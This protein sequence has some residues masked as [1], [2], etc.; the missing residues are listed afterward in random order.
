VEYH[1]YFRL[2]ETDDEYFPYFRRRH[3]F[4]RIYGLD[5]PDEVLRKVYYENALRIIPGIDRSLFPAH[6]DRP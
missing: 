5:L 6:E 3:A 4:W 1:T 2:F